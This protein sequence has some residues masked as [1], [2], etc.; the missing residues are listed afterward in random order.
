[1]YR[2][3]TAEQAAEKMR[4]AKKYIL[5][6]VRTPQEYRAGHVRGAVPVRGGLIATLAPEILPDRDALILLYCNA[7]GRSGRAAAVLPS[8]G[9]KSVYYFG[10]SGWT[11]GLEDG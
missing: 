10:L 9:Y 4:L 2:R 11:Y 1:M 7:G 8:L 6:D 5:L 3:L